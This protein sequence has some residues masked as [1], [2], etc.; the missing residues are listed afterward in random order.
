MEMITQGGKPVVYKSNIRLKFY[1]ATVEDCRVAVTQIFARLLP[2]GGVVVF[3]EYTVFLLFSYFG[4]RGDKEYITESQ[5]MKFSETVECRIPGMGGKTSSSLL[6]ARAA[7]EPH[8]KCGPGSGG[9]WTIEVEGEIE[10][11]IY[12]EKAALGLYL[13]TPAHGSKP[14]G[15]AT[16]VRL[17]GGVN[18]ND[19]LELDTEAIVNHSVKADAKQESEPQESMKAESPRNE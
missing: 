15:G 12:G 9:A 6:D 13:A 7:F 17:E 2:D 8:V 10:V 4:G 18:P 14:A 19:L 11:F 1:S 16:V 3:G 5:H